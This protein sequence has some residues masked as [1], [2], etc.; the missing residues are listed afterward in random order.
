MA[1]SAA[2]PRIPS[3]T[4]RLHVNYDFTFEQARAIVP[5]LHALGISDCYASPFF[6]ASPG[7]NHGYDIVDHN[8]LNAEIGTE[9]EF[10]ALV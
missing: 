5:Y 10:D 9:A 7:S 2:R 3:A 8:H 6:Q 1:A 4:Y